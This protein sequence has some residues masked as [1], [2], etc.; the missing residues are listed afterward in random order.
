MDFKNER[1]RFVQRETDNPTDLPMIPEIKEALQEYLST[2]H[3]IS[4]LD[5]VFLSSFAPYGE[6]SYSV[7]SFT[8]KKHMKLAGI[9][10]LVNDMVHTACVN[11]LTNAST[12]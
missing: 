9:V 4:E 6:I 10:L 11:C 3:P 12:R 5:L 2:E 8:V 7:V 1:I